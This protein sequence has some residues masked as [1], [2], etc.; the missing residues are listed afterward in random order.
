LF[1]TAADG[2]TR[3]AR[4]YRND[5]RNRNC[6]NLN[7]ELAKQ[8]ADL[9]A[10]NKELEAFADSVAHD[11]RAPLRHSVGLFWAIINQPPAGSIQK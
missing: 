11:L 4:R 3:N 2:Y 9:E 6:Y 7:Q 5:N 10:S 1:A 8:A